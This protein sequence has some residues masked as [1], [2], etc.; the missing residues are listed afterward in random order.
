MHR[1]LM[2]RDQ[3]LKLCANHRITQDLKFEI[4]NEKQVRWHAEDYTEGVGKHEMLAARFKHEEEAKQFVKACEDALEILKT[5]PHV[6]KPVQEKPATTPA[7]TASCA[8]N[9]IFSKSSYK[10]SS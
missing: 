8:G 6:A 5:E 2:R 9:F 4:Y 1:I 10:S 3:V 7:N